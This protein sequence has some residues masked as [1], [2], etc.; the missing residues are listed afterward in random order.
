DDSKFVRNSVTDK[1][2]NVKIEGLSAGNFVA[3]FDAD[4]IKTF[5]SFA[6]ID[7]STAMEMSDAALKPTGALT[8]KISLPHSADYAWVQI[9][10]LEYAVK[11]DSA[12]NFRL[13]S[14]PA[15]VFRIRAI[16]YGYSAILAED[17]AEVYSNRLTDAGTI[18][19]PS[20]GSEDPSTWKYSQVVSIDSLISEWMLPLFDSTVI[21]LRL[22]TSNFDF[23]KANRDGSDLRVETIYGESV[24]FTIARY[25]V[26]AKRGVLKIRIPASF[27]NDMLIL[28][29]GHENAINR[30]QS[31]IWKGIPDSTKFKLN[32]VLLSDF[33]KNTTGDNKAYLP[34]PIDTSYWFITKS[35]ADSVTAKLTFEKADSGRTG[36]CAHFAYTYTGS[37]VWSLLGV[38]LPNGPNTL[39]TLDSIEFYA[40]GNGKIS[41]A[42][43]KNIWNATDSTG[44]RSKSW[45]HIA[46]D[47]SW[48]RYAIK[49]SDLLKADSSGG[50][51][52]WDSVKD[53]VTNISFFG[54]GGTGFYLDDIRLYG[55]DRDDLK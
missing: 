38:A 52:G 3:E 8:G 14:L 4:S 37:S 18:A 55:V 26:K 47:S 24:P 1:N 41:L 22:N 29:Y 6:H 43:E 45:I 32:S 50:N 21:T 17:L 19:M 15:G 44:S 28:R 48:V 13:D 42:F 54:S 25:D 9:Y 33:E 7:T 11:T 49:P 36:I 51:L 40:R 30:S 2:G 10:G 16:S 31:N 12:G 53:S 46:I 5:I 20:T 23:T 35:S 39:A 34:Q 27:E